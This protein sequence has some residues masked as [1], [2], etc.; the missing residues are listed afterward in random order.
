MSGAAENSLV[1]IIRENLMFAESHSSGCLGLGWE[2]VSRVRAARPA[3][4]RLRFRKSHE[5]SS[6]SAKHTCA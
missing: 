5:Q 4:H 6:R 3:G 1:Y 2:L